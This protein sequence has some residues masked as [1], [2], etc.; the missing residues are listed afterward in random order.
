MTKNV[1]DYFLEGCG[2]CELGGTPACKV[3]TWKE[4]LLLL[5]TIV[6]ESE[7]TEECKWGC[8]CY[9]FQGKNVLMISAFKESC[10][11]SFFKGSL[12]KDT[13]H[14]LEKAGENSNVGRWLKFKNL[15]EIIAVEQA[16]KAYILEA[17]LLEKEGKKVPPKPL[18][19]YTVPEELR[20]AFLED[21][22]FEI[23][24]NSLTAGRQKGY[25]IF[26]GQAKHTSTR[27]ARIQ[28]FKGKIFQGKGLQDR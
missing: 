8:P 1:E 19:D 21:S 11:L 14:L 7:L 12:L 10:V 27:T 17:I 18:S 26:F 3:H 15:K 22:S 16:I 13:D 20:D 28:K 24:F 5:R 6:L 9:T 2:R 23:A 4:E 25:L